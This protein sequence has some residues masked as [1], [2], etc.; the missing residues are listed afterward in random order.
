MELILSGV[1]FVLGLFV[2]SFLLVLADRLPREENVLVGRSHCES[3]DKPLA[4]YELVPV[5]SYVFQ[6]GKCRSCHASLSVWYP[7]AELLTGLSFALLPLIYPLSSPLLL[8]LLLAV[9][10]TQIVIIIADWKYGIIPFPMVIAGLLFALL[11]YLFLE[12][13]VLVSHL[14][15][16]G[17]VFGLF[18]LLFY[19]TGGKGIGFGD[20]VY[21]FFMGFFLGFPG[22]VI[23][24][25]LAF[26]T[27]AIV[28]LILVLLKRKKL[29]GDTI[30]F[31]PFLVLG[32]MLAFLFEPFF[33]QFFGYLFW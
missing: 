10:S 29:R 24:L 11:W 1:L 19:V 5:L 7:L 12:P 8:L 23:G 3:C 28:S 27:G 21:A 17:I 14:F 25:Y 30:A 9:V 13:S 15:V 4:W 16:G 31:G 2:G 18:F 6:R 26:L 20:V 33:L 32:T 22:I